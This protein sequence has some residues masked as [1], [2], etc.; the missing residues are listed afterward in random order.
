MALIGR[1]TRP[2][3]FVLGIHFRIAPRGAPSLSGFRARHCRAEGQPLE[4]TLVA[5]GRLQQ[6]EKACPTRMILEREKT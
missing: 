1:G 2:A 3:F 4:Q 6:A 5:G